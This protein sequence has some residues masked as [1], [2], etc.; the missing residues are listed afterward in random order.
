MNETK[1]TK[2][3]IH[4]KNTELQLEK[5]KIKA[6]IKQSPNRVQIG[7]NCETIL[8][9]NTPIAALYI[10]LDKI[11]WIEETDNLHFKVYV[12]DDL[13]YNFGYKDELQMNK[14]LLYLI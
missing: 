14:D 3:E 11:K 10:R 6:L 8:K 12:T 2:Q 4:L 13:Y 7:P 1:L 9:K 5:A